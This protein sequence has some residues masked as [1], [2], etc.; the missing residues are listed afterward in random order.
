MDR[1]EL[2]AFFQEVAA[3]PPRKVIVRG[4]TLF[5]RPVTVDEADQQAKD[6]ESVDQKQG[7][8]RAA[9]R[10]ICDEKGARLFDPEN[11]ADVNLVGSTWWPFL[12]TILKAASDDIEEAAAPGN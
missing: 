3:E 9:C 5:V 1:A 2:I 6:R 4:R 7:I 10:V 12:Q 11:S 8:A